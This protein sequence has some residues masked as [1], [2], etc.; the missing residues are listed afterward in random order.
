VRSTNAWINQ[1]TFVSTVRESLFICHIISAIRHDLREPSLGLQYS[2]GCMLSGVLI[3]IFT[4]DR[5]V[6]RLVDCGVIEVDGSH[7][8]P[9]ADGWRSEELVGLFHTTG[10]VK[11]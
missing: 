2:H 6:R 10:L 1:S 4:S 8:T 3:Q 7:P 9:H 5:V 11:V